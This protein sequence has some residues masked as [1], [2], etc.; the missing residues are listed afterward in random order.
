MPDQLDTLSPDAFS[1]FY[2][3][4]SLLREMVPEGR[5]VTILDVGGASPYLYQ[6]LQ[7]VK[8]NFTL[9]VLDILDRPSDI[10]EDVKYIKGDA[11]SR[12]KLMSDSFDFVVTTDTL[13]HIPEKNKPN[14]IKT[15]LKLAKGAVIISGPFD[16]T[17][18][19]SA[20]R[21][22][23][24]LNIKL[25][26]VGQ[27]W[28]EEHFKFGK[29]KLSEVVKDIENLEYEYD[30]LGINNLYSWVVSTHANLI[31]AS[32][33]LDPVRH[34]ELNALYNHRIGLSGELREP[35]YRHALVVY[36]HPQTFR[37]RDAFMLAIGVDEKQDTTLNYLSG[38]LNL[39]ADR[40]SIQQQ[41][42]EELKSKLRSNS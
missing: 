4:A 16:T 14:F 5:P 22:T 20:E 37:A 17:G 31:E 19:D 32:L 39:F 8:L 18:F 13:E 21:L 6:A 24:E 33:G 42:I 38:I 12:S 2:Y 30:V 3:I 36:K 25:F 11:A 7:N 35:T 9:T 10:S 15:C 28:L 1:R 40:I 23:N 34:K 27:K 26:G 29:P 41:E